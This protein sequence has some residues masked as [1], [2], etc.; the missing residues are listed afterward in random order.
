MDQPKTR[1]KAIALWLLPVL[2]ALTTVTLWAG[3][4]GLPPAW[5]DAASCATQP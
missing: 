4:D 1:T 5:A 3:P 2:I